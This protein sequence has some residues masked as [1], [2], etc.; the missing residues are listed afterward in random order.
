MPVMHPAPGV[1]VHISNVIGTPA[2]PAF[3]PPAAVA[4]A[5]YGSAAGSIVHAGSAP[6]SEGPGVVSMMRD[7]AAQ[8][9]MDAVARRGPARM[10]AYGVGT[11][12]LV[13]MAGLLL[14]LTVGV[15]LAAVILAE[16][17]CAAIAAIAF[18]IGRRAGDG[19]GGHHLEQAILRVA[20]EHEGVVRVVALARATGRPLRECQTA[21]DAMVASGHATVDSDERGTLVYRI[22]DLEPSPRLEASG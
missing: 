11:F 17:P 7:D 20:A 10:L 4:Y 13:L 3:Y 14:L 2:A 18:V 8:R 5:P 15:P 22:P 16:V 9:T 1:S 6:P 21:I 12:V 19:V